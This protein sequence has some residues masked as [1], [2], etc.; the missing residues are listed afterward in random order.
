[1]QLT[2]RFSAAAS[3]ISVWTVQNPTATRVI[4]LVLPFVLAAVTALATHQ[5]IYACPTPSGCTGGGDG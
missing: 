1:M 2:A 5:P 4:L 3:Q